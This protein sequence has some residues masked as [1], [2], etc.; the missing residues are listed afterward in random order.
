LFITVAC[1]ACSGFHS[2]VASGT[3]SKQLDRETDVRRV[4]YGGMLVE[5]VLATLSM[6]TIIVLTSTEV[7][8]VGGNPV[9]VFAAGLSKILS[10]LGVPPSLGTDFALLAINTFLLTTLDTCTRLCRFLVEEL[11]G[12]RSLASRYLGTVLVLLVPGVLVF[13]TFDGQPAWRATWPLFGSTN[14]LLAALALLTFAVYLK[15]HR[16]K[17]GFAIYP[18]L[19]MLCMPL[20]AL[21]LMVWQYWGR[22]PLLVW[23][24]IAMFA[25]GVYVAWRGILVLLRP[26]E[27]APG[28]DP[29]GRGAPSPVAAE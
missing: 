17:A 14:Q 23:P 2:I 28:E 12:W 20:A 22:N 13:G 4:A 25:L 16:I 26:I 15:V 19:V 7:A 10:P 5:G 29:G 9:R 27:S 6:G 8:A 3:T 18:T 11:F 21:A 24:A 1:G